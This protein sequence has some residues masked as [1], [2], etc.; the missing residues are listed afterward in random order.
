VFSGGARATIH[1]S[2]ALGRERRNGLRVRGDGG[3]IMVDN[4]LVP[5][6]GHR[7]EITTAGG[8]R[9]EQLAGVTTYDYQ[10]E[11]FVAAVLDGGPRITGGADSIA[12]MRV[13]DAIYRAAGMSPRSP[14]G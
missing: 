2:M 12:T 4:L 5:H 7:L 8:M 9:S 1:C 3:E 14:R 6:N 10:L 11:A 13:L